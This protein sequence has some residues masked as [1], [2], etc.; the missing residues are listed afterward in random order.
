MLSPLLAG[1][2]V[3]AILRYAHLNAQGVHQARSAVPSSLEETFWRVRT[4]VS[5]RRR[6]D[7]WLLWIST[8]RS[9]SYYTTTCSG[10]CSWR[11]I[12]TVLALRLT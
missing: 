12:A 5:L 7:V 1:L 9:E 3:T 8:L 2:G 10:G 6:V 11:L 4:V